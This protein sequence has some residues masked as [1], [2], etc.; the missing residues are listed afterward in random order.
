MRLLGTGSGCGDFFPGTDLGA[1]SISSRIVNVAVQGEAPENLQQHG[2]KAEKLI[3]QQ[4]LPACV[5]PPANAS[6]LST[7]NTIAK[8]A[9]GKVNTFLVDALQRASVYRGA[10]KPNEP[11]LLYCRSGFRKALMD[12]I[13]PKLF[14]F[15]PDLIMLS[16]GVF[17]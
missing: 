13:M 15:K 9:E 17:P 4:K 7:L 12:V 11:P 10:A 3:A 14:E 8:M 5:S 1:T 16:A 2:T 6:D